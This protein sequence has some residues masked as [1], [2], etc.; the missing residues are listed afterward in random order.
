[1]ASS[2]FILFFLVLEVLAAPRSRAKFL[3]F[4]PILFTNHQSPITNHRSPIT[5][6]HSSK[7]DYSIQACWFVRPVICKRC[8][9]HVNCVNIHSRRCSSF[10]TILHLVCFESHELFINIFCFQQLCWSVGLNHLS[11]ICGCW[12]IVRS[13]DWLSIEKFR[14]DIILTLKTNK[15]ELLHH[16]PVWFGYL[17]LCSSGCMCSLIWRVHIVVSLLGQK[18]PVWS[19]YPWNS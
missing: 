15:H 4:S 6:H 13:K 7:K 3:L 1:M 9:S 16:E 17:S 19:P 12:T 11:N 8:P 18:S 10:W 2:Y 5:N 14:L